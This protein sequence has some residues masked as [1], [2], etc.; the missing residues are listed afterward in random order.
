MFD[1]MNRYPSLIGCCQE[2][3]L[4]SHIW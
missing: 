4:Y 1:A 3:Q 2:T